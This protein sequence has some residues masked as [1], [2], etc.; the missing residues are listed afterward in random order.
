[1]RKSIAIFITLFVV[2]TGN[3][4]FAEPQQKKGISDQE[5]QKVIKEMKVKIEE[6]KKIEAQKARE[7]EKKMKAWEAK[8]Q[9]RLSKFKKTLKDVGRFQAIKIMENFVIIL[10]TKEGHLWLW[11]TIVSDSSLT[12]GGQL[13]PG[14]YMG[15][16]TI[17]L[18][19][20]D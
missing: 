1:M 7:I 18:V 20:E 10:D 17:Y 6:S 3:L 16:K 5:M 11:E 15:E 14:E 12:Y 2:F 8:R 19:K 9:P 13:C 4:I